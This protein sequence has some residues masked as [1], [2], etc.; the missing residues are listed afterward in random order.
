MSKT[1][2]LREEIHSRDILVDGMEQRMKSSETQWRQQ[3][4]A[5]HQKLLEAQATIASQDA[6]L[7]TK[8]QEAVVLR[9][10]NLKLSKTVSAPS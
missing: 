5:L 2:A 3:T 1:A 7:V 10:S 8:R 4:S 9:Q 6:M